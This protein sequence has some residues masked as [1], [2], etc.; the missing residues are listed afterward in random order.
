MWSRDGSS[1]RLRSDDMTVLMC[2]MNFWHLLSE[3][4]KRRNDC[5]RTKKP[6]DLPVVGI[7]PRSFLKDNF[8][9]FWSLLSQDCGW[10]CEASVALC[11][12]IGAVWSRDRHVTPRASAEQR[13]SLSL[14]DHLT[15]AVRAHELTAPGSEPLRHAPV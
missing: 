6:G 12:M 11:S 4:L 5:S 2:V 14:P 7:G 15:S 9:R 1:N 10:N 3:S 13:N 8:E